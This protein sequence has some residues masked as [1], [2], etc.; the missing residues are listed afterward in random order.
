MSVRPS[1]L[2]RFQRSASATGRGLLIS[3]ALCV[4]AWQ[5]LAALESTALHRQLIARFGETRVAL[6]NDWITE[7]ETVRP[8][9]EGAKLR[10][11][12]N[13]INQR[14]TFDNDISIWEQSEYWATPLET[15]GQGA[16]DC[17]DFAI[18][19]YVALRLAG[20][21]N[22]KLR[23]IYVKARVN[24]PDGPIP[25]A[26]MVLA[27]YASPNA[28]PT[29]L[30]NLNPAILPAS[31]RS[32]LQPVF[33]FNSEAIFAGVAGKEKA[34]TGGIGRLSR[35]EDAWRRVLAEGYRF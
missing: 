34:S 4:L 14:I 3:I 31:K 6:L 24:G 25:V 32:D 1:L 35:W 2:Y 27:Y 23:L 8:L 33:S 7:I 15:I 21:A 17:E 30:D 22:S 26:H 9:T 13:F 5:G 16:G 19:K 20:V 29:V 12:N 11:I 18:I 28:E 10:R